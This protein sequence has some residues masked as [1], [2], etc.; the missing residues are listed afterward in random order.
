M[1]RFSYRVGKSVSFN[2]YCHFL[3]VFWI[4]GGILGC[5]FALH[6]TDG[7]RDLLM[8]S[9]LISADPIGLI[10]V[11]FLP[12]V[13]SGIAVYLSCRWLLIALSF[14]KAI[15]F[16]FISVGLA[17]CLPASGWLVGFFLLFSDWCMLPILYWFW[18]RVL[19][20][21]STSWTRDIILPAA[22]GVIIYA[23]DLR[24]I[25][26]FFTEILFY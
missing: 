3:N 13:L 15:T 6:L 26:A 7:C 5:L 21:N 23:L 4:L 22:A 25:S 12:L 16:S 14:F 10:A 24:V 17:V 18:L 9:V 20:D 2:P 1:V 19:S 11:V 8:Q